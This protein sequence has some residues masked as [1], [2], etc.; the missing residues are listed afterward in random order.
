MCWPQCFVCL[1]L[2][3]PSTLQPMPICAAASY[4]QS[5]ACRGRAAAQSTI[6]GAKPPQTAVFRLVLEVPELRYGHAHSCLCS[7][8]CASDS[9]SDSCARA[10]ESFYSVVHVCHGET[11]IN[12]WFHL[13]THARAAEA[14]ALVGLARC[15]RPVAVFVAGLSVDVPN[16]SRHMICITSR[17]SVHSM[18]SMMREPGEDSLVWTH[19]A[20]H[21]DGHGTCGACAAAGL[22]AL[23]STESSVML[24][25]VSTLNTIHLNER[26]RTRNNLNLG[27]AIATSAALASHF[28]GGCLWFSHDSSTPGPCHSLQARTRILHQWR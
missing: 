22:Q 21:R 27:I 11:P 19:M 5:T 25:V 23:L 26:E 12:T 3:A 1:L 2:V 8:A 28:P 14:D 18:H 6:E 9:A 7:C 4:R 20:T 13:L 15:P 16:S 17:V 24:T 10:S